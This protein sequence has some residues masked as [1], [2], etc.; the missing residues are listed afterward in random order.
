MERGLQV[1]D[2][3][4]RSVWNGD[5]DRGLAGLERIGWPLGAGIAWDEEVRVE[6]NRGR[7]RKALHGQAGP[8]AG[9]DRTLS[10]HPPAADGSGRTPAAVLRGCSRR[11]VSVARRRPSEVPQPKI[12]ASARPVDGAILS[13][14]DLTK[15]MNA[16]HAARRDHW[17]G[18]SMSTRQPRTISLGHLASRQDP[19]RHSEASWPESSA[20][21]EDAGGQRR[22][23][24]LPQDRY[25]ARRRSTRAHPFLRASH[26]EVLPSDLQAC[27]PPPVPEWAEGR[28]RSLRHRS[29]SRR[30][31]LQGRR[32]GSA[33]GCADQP[34]RREGGVRP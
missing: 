30:Q 1:R 14:G 34:F 19:G 24:D 32:T 8:S 27:P 2:R 22:R 4:W 5:G 17:R 11:R 28:I 29:A 21:G 15:T 31:T 6:R 16:A 7:R 18:S 3:S 9:Y 23:A 26:G 25:A 12:T 13:D 33:L 20:P 10:E